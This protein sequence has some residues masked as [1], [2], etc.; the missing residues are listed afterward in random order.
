LRDGYEALSESER[1]QIAQQCGDI[2]IMPMHAGYTFLKPFHQRME[3][4]AIRFS[5]R[6]LAT[7]FQ[8]AS[9]NTGTNGEEIVPSDERKLFFSLGAH[10]NAIYLD[11][12]WGRYT[13]DPESTKR[14]VSEAA[15]Q[16]SVVSLSHP[17]LSFFDDLIAAKVSF[18]VIFSCPLP[19]SFL[20]R[21]KGTIGSAEELAR[22]MT[23]FRAVYGRELRLRGVQF[24]LPPKEVLDGDFLKEEF[25]STNLENDFHANAKYGAVMLRQLFGLSRD[26]ASPSAHTNEFRN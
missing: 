15:F 23:R 1:R 9:D 11:R 17:V 2:A 8:Q 13:I 16:R 5:R 18:E 4:G 24:H 26:R 10:G 19:R 20:E 25:K 6:P 22:I 7:R 12:T 3:T 21:V 14:Y